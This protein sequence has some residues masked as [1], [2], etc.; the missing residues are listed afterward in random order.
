MYID[1][2]SYK[3]ILNRYWTL[4]DQRDFLIINLHDEIYNIN[5]LNNQNEPKIIEQHRGSLF[6]GLKISQVIFIFVIQV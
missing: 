5:D 1:L 2:L 3:I 4:P 6:K